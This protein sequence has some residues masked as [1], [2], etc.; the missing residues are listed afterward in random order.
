MEQRRPSPPEYTLEILTDRTNVKDIVK[1]VLHA[2]FFHRYFIPIEPCCRDVLD[3]TMSYIADD[4]LETLI[5]QRATALARALDT[6]STPSGLPSPQYNQKQSGRGQVVL[7]FL[8]KKRKKG[9]GFMKGGEEE[10]CWEVWCLNVTLAMPRTESDSQKVRNAMEK[11]LEKTAF[12]I[13]TIVNRDRGHIP[14]ITTTET[15]PF[16]YQILVN[17]KNDG[18]GQRMGIFN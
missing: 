9:W 14:P 6:A 7:Q 11:S 15:N 4:D 12:K 2:I 8:E 1:A 13:V 16:P 17:P 18:W 5:D 3:V 10:L